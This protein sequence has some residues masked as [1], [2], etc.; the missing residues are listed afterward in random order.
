MA[1]RAY[2][3]MH[4]NGQHEVVPADW[5]SSR[6]GS[7]FIVFGLGG[8]QTG[9]QPY[10][11]YFLPITEVRGVREVTGF[12]TGAVETIKRLLSAPRQ[13]SAPQPQSPFD[14]FFGEFKD[15]KEQP[16]QDREVDP[17]TGDEV[18]TPGLP[19]QSSEDM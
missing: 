11:F 19:P 8:F 7:P 10:P 5:V 12:D 9:G 6:E 3:V 16:E 17:T 4:A 1:A 13:R 14:D 18:W 2:F 15:F